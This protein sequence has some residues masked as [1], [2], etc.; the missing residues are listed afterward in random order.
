M[1]D[2]PSSINLADKVIDDLS[3][4]SIDA[5]EIA[6]TSEQGIAVT[7]RQQDLE[8]LEHHQEHGLTITLYQN[9]RCVSVSTSD[10]CTEAIKQC[11]D[12]GCEMVKYVTADPCHGLASKDRLAFQYPDL[13]LYHPWTITAAKAQQIAMECEQIA[14]EQD[15]RITQSEGCHVSTYNTIQLLANSHGFLGVFPTTTHSISCSLL[16]KHED[17]QRDYD[18]TTARHPDSLDEVATVAKAAAQK[19]VNRLNAQPL[20]TRRCPVI[21]DRRVAKGLIAT[22]ISAIT[23]SQLYRNTSFL[24]DQL[25]QAIFAEHVHIYQQPHLPG[26][27]GSAAFDSDGVTTTY[28]DY[29]TQGVLSNYVLSTYSARRLNMQSTGNAGGVFNLTVSHSDITFQQLLKKMD[30]GLLVTELMGQG[31]N[32]LTGEYSRAA[33]GYWVEHGEIQCPV[34]EITIA[35]NLKDMYQQISAISNDID[36]RGNLRTGSILIEQMTVAGT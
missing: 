12:R 22:L 36:Q 3:H 34:T 31:I 4:R 20:S 21:F 9:Q 29:I 1:L 35:G 18:Y 10:F 7:V 2:Q 33:F 13:D 24:V 14:L 23:G 8:T 28:Q 6:M 26:A 11:I 17:M 25:N 5:Y 32:L 19:T 16:A 15:E 30:T 27:M